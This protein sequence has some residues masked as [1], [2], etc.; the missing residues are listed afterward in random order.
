VDRSRIVPVVKPAAWLEA[1]TRETGGPGSGR[2][3][4]VEPLGPE[5]C[6]T[7]A[8]DRPSSVRI[9]DET[10]VKALGLDRGALRTLAAANLATVVPRFEVRGGDGV[11]L[12]EAD[13]VYASSLVFWQGLWNGRLAVKGDPVVSIPSREVLLVTGSDDPAGLARVR[14]AAARLR[15]QSSFPLARGLLVRRAGGLEPF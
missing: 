15:A 10:Q 4:V 6:V 13:G 5:L 2:M 11:Y 9:L 3:P 14:E 7:Y 12:V 1:A 8:E